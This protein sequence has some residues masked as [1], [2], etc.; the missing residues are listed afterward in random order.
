MMSACLFF[1]VFTLPFLIIVSVRFTRLGSL[2]CG[3]STRGAKGVFFSN[4]EVVVLSI[5]VGDGVSVV[6]VFAV[7][8][9]DV[10]GVSFFDAIVGSLRSGTLDF[11]SVIGLVRYF[12]GMVVS[13]SMIDRLPICIFMGLAFLVV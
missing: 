13:V 6:L 10:L 2:S 3:I 5:G 8:V 7:F 9:F 1:F 11:F 4:A 12:M